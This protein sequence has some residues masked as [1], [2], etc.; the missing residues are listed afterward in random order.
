MSVERDDQGTDPSDR[1][2]NVFRAGGRGWTR[3]DRKRQV[4]VSSMQPLQE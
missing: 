4:A 3:D 2:E 1:D